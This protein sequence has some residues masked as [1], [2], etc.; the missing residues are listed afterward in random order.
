MTDYELLYIVP[1]SL[2]EEEA[3]TVEQAVGGMLA[4]TNAT[5]QS[6]KR[7]GKLQF[8]YAMKGQHHGYYV[9]VR[10]QAEPKSV[11]ELNELLRLSPDKVLRHI[12]LRAE[13]AGDEKFDLVQF[14]PVNV[15]DRGDRRRAPGARDK[16]TDKLSTEDT[17]AQKE[18]V[19]ALEGAASSTGEEAKPLS[20]E[21]LDKK[22]DAAL[23]EKA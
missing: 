13:E 17:K 6:T 3:G 16:R 5:V 20:T 12:I 11:N 23:D 7:L 1:T 18:G 15:E 2:T 10:F 8:A 9:L 22:I 4:K 21:D 19:A 14:Q